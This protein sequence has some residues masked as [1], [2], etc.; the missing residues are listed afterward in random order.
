MMVYISILAAFCFS[1]SHVMNR[2]GLVTSNA[3]TGSLFSISMSAITLWVLVPFFVPLSSFWTSAIWYFVLGG[4][5]APGLGRTLNFI[6]IERVGLARSVPISNSSPM[7]ASILAVLILGETWTLQNIL[8]TTLVITGVVILSQKGSSQAQ[9]R[10]VDLIFPVMASL[11]F[12]VSVLS[13]QK[14]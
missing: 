11:S 4:I 7:F 13:H 9:W 12:A 1:F 3:M 6:G 10:K 8:G 2:R 5:F 14:I